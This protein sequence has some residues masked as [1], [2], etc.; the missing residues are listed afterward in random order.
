MKR[1]PT[2]STWG[3]RGGGA[4]RT[5]HQLNRLKLPSVTVASLVRPVLQQ[6][7]DLV[8][9]AQQRSPITRAMLNTP[10]APHGSGRRN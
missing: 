1:T 10:F 4:A 2:D 6:E 8:A 7:S 3:G 5:V 9:R